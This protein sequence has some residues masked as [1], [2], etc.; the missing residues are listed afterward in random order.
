[1]WESED[2]DEDSAVTT[3]QLQTVS[4]T[5]NNY[6]KLINFICMF[7]LAWQALFRIPDVAAG[8]VFKFMSILLK[9][10][11]LTST[12]TLTKVQEFF[13]DNLKKAHAMQSINTNNFSQLIVCPKCCSTYEQADFTSRQEIATCSYVRFPRHPH[14]NMRS[15]CGE[16][17]MK[18]VKTA[19]KN[20]ILVPLKVFC[21]NSII[22]TIKDLVQRPGILDIFSEWKLRKIP[23]GVMCDIYDGEL[24]KSFLYTA[25]QEEL[26]SSRYTL[27]LLLNVDWF[28]PYKHV[29]YSTGAIYISF[30]NFPRSLRYC[31]G[32]TFVVGLLPGP[33]EPKL[34]MNSFL[35]NIVRELLLLWKGVRMQTPEGEKEIK[36]VLLCVACDTPASRKIGGFMGHAALK[37]CSRCLK[38]FPT[39]NF[40]EKSDYSGFNRS[41]DLLLSI[42]NRGC[43][44]NMQQPYLNGKT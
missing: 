17:L 37:G 22:D 24:W 27:G 4:S 44:G 40:G 2:S 21:Y 23:E 16:K 6:I 41:L 30:L 3:E 29:Q 38:S 39:K 26:L 9:K 13:P 25:D 28:Q 8:L 42:V 31:N 1:M 19:K 7:L 14:Q 18:A 20:R 43:R 11:A 5:D 33:H 12:Q 35:E 15:K 32:N 36:A 34:H 10:L